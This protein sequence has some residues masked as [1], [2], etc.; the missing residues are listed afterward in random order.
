MLCNS[1]AWASSL[2][3][4]TSQ[5]ITDVMLDVWQPGAMSSSAV[6]NCQCREVPKAVCGEDI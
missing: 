4:L 3:R 6:T 5:P 1:C 2:L